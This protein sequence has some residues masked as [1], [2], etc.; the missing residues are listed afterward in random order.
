[1]IFGVQ[2]RKDRSCQEAELARFVYASH[3]RCLEQVA[4]LVE[5]LTSEEPQDEDESKKGWCVTHL[6]EL[7]G[8]VQHC[9]EKAINLRSDV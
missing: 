9:G 2:H 5:L 8:H 6:Y 4:R 1:M 3:R 7:V